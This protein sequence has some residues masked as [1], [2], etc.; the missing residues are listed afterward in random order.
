MA[1][2]QESIYQRRWLR[3]DYV[4]AAR[5]D[6][7]VKRDLL[8]F[9]VYES[10]DGKYVVDAFDSD[11]NEIRTF[12]VDRFVR[13]IVGDVMEGDDPCVMETRGGE[14]AV[15]PAAWGLIQARPQTVKAAAV[16]KFLAKGWALQ[17]EPVILTKAA[18][19]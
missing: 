18:A 9:R 4:S 3:V 13:V 11:H 19:R 5:P 10:R 7:T 14:V 16:D 8:P 15:Y 17:P 12:R 2:I 1:A 6:E